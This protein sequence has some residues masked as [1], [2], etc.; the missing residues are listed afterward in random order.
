MK[1]DLLISIET[2]CNNYNVQIT[3]F[4]DLQEIGLVEIITIEQSDY[5]YEEKINE[6]EKMIRFHQDLNLNKE[7]I[8]VVFNLLN[9]INDLQEELNSLKNKVSISQNIN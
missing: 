4:R 6:V 5:I 7:A 9:K 1:N 2:L 8:D 3:F